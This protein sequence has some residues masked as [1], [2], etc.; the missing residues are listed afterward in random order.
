MK[1]RKWK[2]T[3][4]P[5]LRIPDERTGLDKFA[6]TWAQLRQMISEEWYELGGKGNERYGRTIKNSH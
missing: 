2:E 4:L 5:D 3:I 1:E 6:L